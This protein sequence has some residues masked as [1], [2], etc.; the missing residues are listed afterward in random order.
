[1]LNYLQYSDQ[2]EKQNIKPNIQYSDIALY[3]KKKKK[4]QK[5]GLNLKKHAKYRQQ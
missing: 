4:P 5:K 2:K 1:M 3:I